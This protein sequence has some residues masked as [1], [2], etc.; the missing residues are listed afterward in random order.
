VAG[1]QI[2]HV[3]APT[4]VPPNVD[5]HGAGLKL[6][7]QQI[8]D[9]SAHLLVDVVFGQ[10][11]GCRLDDLA[12]VGG[13]QSRDGAG[14]VGRGS[15]RGLCWR[16]RRHRHRKRRDGKDLLCSYSHH[17]WILL[18]H[19][20]TRVDYHE[21]RR[22]IL[23]MNTLVGTTLKSARVASPTAHSPEASVPVRCCDQTT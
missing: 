10:R 21:K 17:R 7:L 8:S 18:L 6:L 12:T 5:D 15:C 14:R 19:C 4:R 23:I 1:Q 13:R 16:S 20:P 3:P 22:L 2:A 11:C 9:G